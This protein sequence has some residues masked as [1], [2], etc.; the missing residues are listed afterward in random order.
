[1]SARHSFLKN[2][3]ISVSAEDR[4]RIEDEFQRLLGENQSL[5]D[6]LAR[7]RQVIQDVRAR[8]ANKRCLCRAQA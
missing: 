6:E 8:D 7:L 1:M 4:Q 3:S 5:T 2:L